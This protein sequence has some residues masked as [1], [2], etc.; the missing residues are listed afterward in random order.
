LNG[1]RENHD[2]FTALGARVLGLSVESDRAHTAFAASLDLPF[3]LLSDF[4]REV[5]GQFGIAYTPDEPF[6]GFWG[7][8][9]RSVFVL[10]QA[11]VVRYAWVT[12]DPLVAPDVDDVLAAVSALGV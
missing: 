10:D 7:M 1:F 9:R 4:N 3:P 12:D 11:G 8:S 5:I 2:R 6:S